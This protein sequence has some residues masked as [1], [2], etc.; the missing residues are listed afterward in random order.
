MT[1]PCCPCAQV[2]GS[3]QTVGPVARAFTLDAQAECQPSVLFLRSWIAVA[4]HWVRHARAWSLEHPGLLA[5]VSGVLLSRVTAACNARSAS[6]RQLASALLQTQPE[7]ASA[8]Q[9]APQQQWA[10]RAQLRSRGR[11]RERWAQV[12]VWIRQGRFWPPRM[13]AMA[14]RL[15]AAYCRVEAEAGARAAGGASHVYVLPPQHAFRVLLARWR[16]EAKKK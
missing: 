13:R 9:H 10:S 6:E 7:I 8:G 1:A 15:V 11:A 5:R 2:L 4:G 3:A 16:A 14:L 12:F